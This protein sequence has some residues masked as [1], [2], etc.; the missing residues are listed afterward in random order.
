MSKQGTQQS[1]SDVQ[2][3]AEILIRDLLSKQLVIDLAPRRLQ[4]DRVGAVGTAYVD[5]DGVAPG[6]S[7]LVEIFGVVPV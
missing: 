4:V 2:K 1:R 3:E 6:E 5:V 7:V